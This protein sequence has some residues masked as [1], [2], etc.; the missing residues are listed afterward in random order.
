[1]TPLFFTLGNRKS[2]MIIPDTLAHLNGHTIL[3]HTYNIYLDN[4]L[5]EPAQSR[6]KESAL[7]LQTH[8]DPNY[9]GF[10]T[11]ENPGNIF[12][13]A[14]DGGNE[15]GADEVQE[16]V[17]DIRHIRDNPNLWQQPSSDS[18]I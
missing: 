2:L 16:L 4:G 13:Y 7:H 18:E 9:Y 11:I 10:I 15:L 14:S 8:A 1:M 5:N 12:T 3:T 6:S 17:E